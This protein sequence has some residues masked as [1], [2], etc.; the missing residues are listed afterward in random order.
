[1][2]IHNHDEENGIPCDACGR[3]PDAV[4]QVKTDQRDRGLRLCTECFQAACRTY[5]AQAKARRMAE[6]PA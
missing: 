1:M 3:I 5:A 4:I 6:V 2:F